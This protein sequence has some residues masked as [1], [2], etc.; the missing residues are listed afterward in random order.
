MASAAWERRNAQARAAGYRNYYDYRVHNYGARPARE[1]VDPASRDLLRGH[2]SRA[3]LDRMISSGRVLTITPLTGD[4]SSRSGQ[5]RW[6]EMLVVTVDGRTITYRLRGQQASRS[7]LGGLAGTIGGAGI[8]FL[9]N[10]SLDVLP[11]LTSEIDEDEEDLDWL[12][13]ELDDEDEEE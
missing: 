6:V 10:P 13:D 3:D 9:P 8:P 12:S 5:Y 4:R 11:S 1:P 7:A 2:R